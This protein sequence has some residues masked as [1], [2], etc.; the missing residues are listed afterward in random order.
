MTIK[1]NA[2]GKSVI[3]FLHSKPQAM[4]IRKHPKKEGKKGDLYHRL[5]RAFADVRL[6]MDGKKK[7]KTLDELI[8]ELRNSNILFSRFGH[9]QTITDKS[10]TFAV[11]RP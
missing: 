6:M 7:K 9:F 8:D 5:D 3:A 10:K 2:L 11:R 4:T 1:K